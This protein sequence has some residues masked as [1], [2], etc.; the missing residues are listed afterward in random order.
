LT[1]PDADIRLDLQTLLH[2][3]YDAADYGKYIY[4][5]APQAPL[6]EAA[7]AWARQFVPSPA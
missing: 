4:G 5:E 1:A 6:P 2:H 3:V 7:A